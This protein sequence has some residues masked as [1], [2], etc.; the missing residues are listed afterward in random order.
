[1]LSEWQFRYETRDLFIGKE[2][3]FRGSTDGPTEVD[4][5]LVD[6][7]EYTVKIV[8]EEFEP[9]PGVEQVG[10]VYVTVP[11][12]PKVGRELAFFLAHSLAERVSYSS[13]DF[14]IDYAFVRCKRIGETE[15][16]I[17]EIGGKEHLVELSLQEVVAA[18][19]FDSEA[20]QKTENAPLPL[21]ALFNETNR[22]A[23]PVRR[24]LGFFRI[25][26]ST[27]YGPNDR[28]ALK[29]ALR[30]NAAARR[31][32]E[33]LVPHGDFNQFVEEVVEAR[34]ECAHLKIDKGFGYSPNDPEVVNVVAPLVP[35]LQELARRCI[36]EP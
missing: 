16:E 5:K 27:S 12:R 34:H 32:Y 14:R 23:S 7:F 15:E 29:E 28:R 20:F 8:P 11:F 21:L 17:V 10:S 36:G 25:L 31:H 3:T 22:D 35:L 2:R 9:P 33:V 6:P 30:T 1:M 13:G 18:P 26:E 24:F 4:G 19:D